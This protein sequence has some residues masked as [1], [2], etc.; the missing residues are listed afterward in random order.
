MR[1][2]EHLLLIENVDVLDI[3]HG[4][5]CSAYSFYILQTPLKCHIVYCSH[6]YA[7]YRVHFFLYQY[8]CYYHLKKF[9]NKTSPINV[10]SN[11][12][13][14]YIVYTI[15]ICIDCI[16]CILIRFHRRFHHQYMQDYY[17]YVTQHY[18]KMLQYR[19]TVKQSGI[20]KFNSANGIKSFMVYGNFIIM[21]MFCVV[22]QF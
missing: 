22:W 15:P 1:C 19:F 14:M 7:M 3:Q 20:N 16:H 4:S 12:C 11:I 2:V 9:S 17:I 5:T 10:Q 13:V 8:Y 21:C 6:C 18:E